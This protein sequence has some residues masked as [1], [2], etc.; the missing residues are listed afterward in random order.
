MSKI[1]H[2]SSINIIRDIDKSL[3][4]IPTLNTTRIASFIVDE[5]ERGIHSFNIIGSYG[6]GKSSF[7]WAFSKSINIKESTNYFELPTNKLKE[8]Q[9]INIVGEYNSLIDYFKS[10]FSIENRLKGNQEIF[11]C[12]FSS[13]KSI[14][15]K[16]GLLVICIDEFGK[17]LEYASHNNPER[18]MYFIQQLAEWTCNKKVDN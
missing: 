6:T 7:L 4:Y 5:F 1:K 13:Y 3:N 11:D 9:Y 16:D 15:K 10:Y 17:F 12:I 8:V 18:E 2:Q 14:S